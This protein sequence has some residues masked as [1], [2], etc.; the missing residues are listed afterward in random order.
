MPKFDIPEMIAVVAI[1]LMKYLLKNLVFFYT[2]LNVY[3]YAV[4]NEKYIEISI[5]I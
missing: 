1:L 4:E 5:G 2:P 3:N